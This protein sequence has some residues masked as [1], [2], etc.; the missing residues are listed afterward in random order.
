[1]DRGSLMLKLL[2]ESMVWVKTNRPIFIVRLTSLTSIVWGWE[3]VYV[4]FR[5]VAGIGPLWP[6][7]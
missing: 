4:G 3:C 1:M 6:S 7:R 5:A 2:C